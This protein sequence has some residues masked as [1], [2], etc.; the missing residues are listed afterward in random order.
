MERVRLWV[1]PKYVA[2]DI[3]E[4]G[5]KVV[6]SITT[7][8]CPDAGIRGNKVYR[9]RFYDILSMKF[10]PN[11]NISICPMSGGL[12]RY[13]AE[14]IVSELKAGNTQVV[15]HCEAGVSRSPAVALAIAD[16]FDT[17]PTKQALLMMYPLYNKH[18]RNL[19]HRAIVNVLN[20]RSL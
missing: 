19:V 3:G 10:D 4:F 5:D 1:I 20:E 18:V 14:C 2:E 16:V 8:G 9:F 13:M 17:Y 12:A 6:L 11:K 7:P 15:I